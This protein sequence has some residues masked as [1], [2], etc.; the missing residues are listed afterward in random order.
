MALLFAADRLDHL[1]SEVLPNLRDGVTVICDRYYHSSIAYQSA[2][3]GGPDAISWLRELNRQA[4]RPDLTLVL[5]VPAKVA[6]E[7][8]RKRRGMTEIFDD[9]ALQGAL[10]EIY[11]TLERHFPGER[12]AHVS[13]TGS[14]E[15]IAARVM[16]E[17]EALRG[18]R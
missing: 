11:L 10:C 2:T 3:G 17:V 1:D 8:R 18:S 5:D 12:V 9:D 14:V 16:A 6:A 7:R 4:R 13:G 15:E